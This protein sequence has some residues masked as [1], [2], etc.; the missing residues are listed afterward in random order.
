MFPVQ[1]KAGIRFK[2]FDEVYTILK[3]LP[4]LKFE[5]EEEQFKTVK[6]FTYTELI[7]HL[8]NGDLK[9][10][11]IGKNLETANK[12]SFKTSFFIENL[13]DSKHKDCA[14]FRYEVIRPILKLSSDKRRTAIISRVNEVNSWSTNPLVAKENLNECTFYQ[15]ISR[16]SVYRWI[17]QYEESSGDVRSLFPSYHCSGGKNKAR[18]DSQILEFINECINDAYNKGQRISEK[19]LWYLIIYK[20]SEFNK[21]SAKKLNIPSYQTI[22]R[23]VIKIPLYDLIA[24]RHGKR[25]ADNRFKEID[26]GLKVSYILERVEIDHTP[27]DVILVDENGDIL[28]RPYLILAIDKYSR[29]VLGFSI[30][31]GNNVGWPEVMQCIK[32]IMSDKSYVKEI[33]PF[34]E[35]EWN[36]FGI[37]ETVVVDNGLEFKNN[38]MKDASYQLGFV[39]QFCPPKVPQ[40]KGSIERFLGTFNRGFA[41]NLPATTRSNPTELGDDENPS[42]LACLTFSVFIALVHKWIID[43]YSQDFNK[44]AG[45]IPAVIW[46]K[47]MVNHPVPLPNNISETAILLGKTAFRKITRLGIELNTLT[48]NNNLLNKLLMQFTDEN[49]GKNE[50]FL[51]KYNPQDISEIRV[52]DKLIEKKWLKV[53]C[54]NYK[55]AKNLSEWEHKEIK[56]YS[57]RQFGTVDIESL[58]RAKFCI[59]QMIEN[60]IGYTKGVIARANKITSENEIQKKLLEKAKD[61][62]NSSLTTNSN[63]VTNDKPDS[64][65]LSDISSRTISV[66]DVTIPESIMNNKTTVDDVKVIEINS[67]VTKK[68]AHSKK[69]GDDSKNEQVK[70]EISNNESKKD[71]SDISDMLGVGLDELFK[72]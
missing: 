49:N 66:P 21:F 54:T 18:S 26:G 69:K 55:Y 64:H 17:K 11:C 1:L 12:S 10:E 45:G 47:S 56:A 14:L 70:S 15:T 68:K 48:Y 24:K 40:W 57:K 35:H 42:K 28:G 3:Q 50:D 63:F 30:G 7:K 6:I 51:V 46:E 72:Q 8:C 23:Y 62:T 31:M 59:R 37:P 44:G 33:Y 2:L 9:F 34:I 5:A 22:S 58:A 36:A 19:E 27:I 32:H 20:I 71:F 25:A 60:G 4:N 13:Q 53:N 43:V 16:A 39:L 52:Y 61:N 65:G 29:E 38:A 67:G 41:H